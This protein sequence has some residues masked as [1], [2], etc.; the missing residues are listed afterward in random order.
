MSLDIHDLMN[1][2]DIHIDPAETKRTI[3]IKLNRYYAA[4]WHNT[5]DTSTACH[6]YSDYK[7][8]LE[9]EPYLTLL[10]GNLR[11]PLTKFRCSNNY[12]PI[13]TGRYDNTPR[14]ERL[15]LMCDSQEVGDEFHYLFKCSFFDN[16]RRIYIDNHYL[17]CPNVLDMKQLLNSNDKDVLEKLSRFVSLIMKQ[18]KPK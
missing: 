6:S 10:E 5:L 18:L 16:D 17:T 3:R 12:L 11:I 9:P 2:H 7:E 1:T 8:K 4:E 14:Q 15:C 13:V